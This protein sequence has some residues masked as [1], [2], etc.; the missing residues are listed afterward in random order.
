M[1][2]REVILVIGSISF[3]VLIV[4]FSLILGNRFHFKDCPCPKVIPHNFVWLF[5]GLSV[6]FVGS[7]LYYLFSIK[8]SEKEKTIKKN[9]E[10]IYSILDE[11]EKKVL[12]LLVKNKGKLKQLELSDRYGKT[13]AHRIIKKLEDKKIVEIIKTGRINQIKLRK[14]LLKEL[15]EL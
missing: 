15:V 8:I 9:I 6:V 7:L 5:I 2:L 13:K 10:V 4:F 3:L 14:G 11:D 12:D 1:N